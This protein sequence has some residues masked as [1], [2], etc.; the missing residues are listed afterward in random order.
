MTSDADTPVGEIV[1]IETNQIDLSSLVGREITIFTDQ[2]QG[3]PLR[4]KVI[5]VT[6][7]VLSVDRGGGS[8]M[9]DCLISN[10]KA[11]VKP[12][13]E[14]SP[15]LRAEGQKVKSKDYRRTDWTV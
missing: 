1:D 3:K 2:F 8:G 6:G 9:I 5:M 15:E 10:Q 12:I 7:G 14:C 13:F 4:T 11:I